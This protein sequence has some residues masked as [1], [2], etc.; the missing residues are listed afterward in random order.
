LAFNG[1]ESLI[2]SV[3]PPTSLVDRLGRQTSLPN[4]AD[5]SG[6]G[7]KKAPGAH[8]I[9]IMHPVVVCAAEGRFLVRSPIEPAR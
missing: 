8:R 1:V 6:K 9:Q 5:P 7:G 4:D 3:M 2:R